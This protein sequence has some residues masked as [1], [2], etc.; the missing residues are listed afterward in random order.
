[1]QEMFKDSEFIIVENKADFKKTSSM[2][3][4][5]SCESKEGI[6][7]LINEIISKI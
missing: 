7:V 6:D 3:I 1:M 4:K 2:N 5:V